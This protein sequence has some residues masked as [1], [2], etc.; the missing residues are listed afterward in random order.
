MAEFRQLPGSQWNACIA[1]LRLSMQ[2]WKSGK[3]FK[4]TRWGALMGFVEI[5]ASLF[6]FDGWYLVMVIGC[7]AGLVT[8]GCCLFM[9]CFLEN[10][11]RKTPRNCMKCDGVQTALVVGKTGRKAHS[12]GYSW[13]LECQQCFHE[14]DEWVGWVDLRCGDGGME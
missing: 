3:T 1:S 6:G 11:Y 4:V 10:A 8:V 5:Q 13:H 9:I 12:M 7:C 14:F 2:I